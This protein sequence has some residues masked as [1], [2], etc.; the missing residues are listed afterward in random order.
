[1]A[2]YL[3]MRIMDGALDYTTIFNIPLYKQ[4][5]ADVDAILVASG[6]HDLIPGPVT[7]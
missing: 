2:A 4:F 6:R 3:A 7:E 5:Q 1:M